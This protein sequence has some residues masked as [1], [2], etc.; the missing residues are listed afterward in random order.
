MAAA[1]QASDFPLDFHYAYG[2]PQASAAIKLQPEH[3]IVDEQLGFEPCGQGEHLY[4]HLKKTG[5]NTADVARQLARHFGVKEMDVG[6]AGMKDKQA[7][8]T[9]WFSL[10]LPKGG[11]SEAAAFAMAGTELLSVLRHTQKLRRGQHG[12]NR[13]QL[14]LATL[15]GDPEDLQRRLGLIAE[16]G[17]PN[18]FGPQRFGIE[19]NNLLA[20]NRWFVERR[21]P[22]SRNTKSIYLSAARSYLFNRLLSQRVADGS[23]NVIEAGDIPAV[24]DTALPTGPLWGR[25]RLRS[26]ERVG[27]LEQQL[28]EQ[29][30]QWCNALE[31][32]GLQQE[33][34]SLCLP[35]QDLRWHLSAQQLELEFQLPVGCFATSVIREICH[36][37]DMGRAGY[38]SEG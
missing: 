25:G 29:F 30:A 19:G 21:A 7:V 33:R 31:H 4:L 20:A 17:V 22:R 24:A 32:S 8:T 28:A 35:L 2:E 23:W 1:P 37:R 34:R 16:H 6:Y 14:L 38:R 36:Y 12:G 9:Q 11:D 27:A 13:F 26:T 3:F 15:E 18:Y 10:Y 5:I